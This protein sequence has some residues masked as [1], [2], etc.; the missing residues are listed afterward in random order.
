MLPSLL[1][2][3]FDSTKNLLL[4]L[5]TAVFDMR[6][7]EM[8]VARII[9]AAC[10]ALVCTQVKGDTLYS[11]DVVDALYSTAVSGVTTTAPAS[12]RTWSSFHEMTKEL[13][14]EVVTSA[15]FIDDFIDSACDECE[16]DIWYHDWINETTGW[17]VKIDCATAVVC[18]LAHKED[19]VRYKA[20][21]VPTMHT[22]D[23]L[24]SVKERSGRR[25]LTSHDLFSSDGEVTLRD[26]ERMVQEEEDAVHS[27]KKRIQELFDATTLMMQHYQIQHYLA[28]QTIENAA[29]HHSASS[30]LVSE[31]AHD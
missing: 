30:P 2:G 24:D 12:N 29:L 10:F 7:T 15:G 6:A 31:L 21:E 13:K 9:A 3:R 18:E 23:S 20:A 8:F 22:P 1:I 16:V 11:Q 5:L 26:F 14:P 17:L 25:L 28:S 4:A 19:E 27:F